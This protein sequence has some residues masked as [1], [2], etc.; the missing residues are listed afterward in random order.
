MLC[1]P[2]QSCAVLAGEV[3]AQ[4]RAGTTCK[5]AACKAVSIQHHCAVLLPFP[6]CRAGCWAGGG[7]CPC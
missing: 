5:N 6:V 1:V 7:G 2:E 3:A 4:V